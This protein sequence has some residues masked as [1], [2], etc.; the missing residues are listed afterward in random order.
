MELYE[1]ILLK[2]G[3]SGE[4]VKR[5]QTALEIPADGQFG[6]STEEA[7]KAFQEQNALEVDGVAGPLTLSKMD[8]FKEF[9][10]EIV[11]ASQ[12]QVNVWDTVKI[13][14]K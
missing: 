14:F 11:A 12:V 13:F 6:S 5:L 3:T 9:T 2:V 7:V 4:I 1:L 10:P 8:A